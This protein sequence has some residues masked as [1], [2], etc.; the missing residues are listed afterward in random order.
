MKIVFATNNLNK[1][2][3]IKAFMP[4]GIDIISLEEVGC[5]EDI[6]ETGDKLK[7][8]ALEKARYLKNYYGFDCFA[9]DSGLEIETLNGAPGVYSA[10]YAGPER[11]S[12]ANM[13]KVL[14]EL[15]GHFNRK[16]KFRT[17]IALILNG[18]EYLFEGIVDG[19]ISLEKNGNEGFGYDPIFFPE[20]SDRSFGQMHI[21]EKGR[22][23]HRGRA[24]KKLVDFIT[25]LPES[26]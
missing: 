23:S 8:N 26:D 7:D 16:A 20:N 10:R 11:N 13:D 5:F 9:D 12:Q 18:K 24:V 15:E 1:L 19:N 2:K 21:E 25:S 6:P 14:K 17:S 3:E 4:Q 22:I